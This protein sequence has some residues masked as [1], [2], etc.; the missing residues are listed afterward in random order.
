MIC[1]PSDDDHY[2]DYDYNEPSGG[3]LRLAADRQG[4]MEH[5]QLR[6]SACA[7]QYAAVR[8]TSFQV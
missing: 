6:A 3:R 2:D 8:L 7:Q 1:R 4:L 5:V